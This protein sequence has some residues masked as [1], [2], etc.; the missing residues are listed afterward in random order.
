MPARPKITLLLAGASGAAALPKSMVLPST[1]EK[2]LEAATEKLHMRRKA[3]AICDQDGQP[4]PFHTIRDNHI[5]VVSSERPVP[6]ATST[7]RQPRPALSGTVTERARSQQQPPPPQPAEM[8]V[9][10]RQH[11]ELTESI[12]TGQRLV[13][14]LRAQ[15]IRLRS[16]ADDE[17]AKLER[18]RG[19]HQPTSSSATWPACCQPA[20]SLRA[21]LLHRS[22]RALSAAAWLSC[23]RLHAA[24]ARRREL[25]GGCRAG[26]AARAAA[27]VGG[28]A[29][30]GAGRETIAAAGGS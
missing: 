26:L 8:A 2:L 30:G 20:A 7:R 12:Q 6:K 28:G 24:T 17:R 13:R 23:R 18:L 19:G 5:V 21:R 1:L 27:G 3:V 14:E 16:K 29:G 25:A 11:Q 10:R 4:L 15:V 22:T 9:V